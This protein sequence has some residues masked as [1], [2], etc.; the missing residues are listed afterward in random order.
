MYNPGFGY[1]WREHNG[2][3]RGV[4]E[5]GQQHFDS[6]RE[7]LDWIP[8]QDYLRPVYRDDGLMVGWRKWLGPRKQLD[9]V[10]WQIYVNGKKPE[11]LPGSTNDA[12]VVEVPRGAT[13]R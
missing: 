5:E 12:I 11:R 3:A 2:I 9:V 4:L 8:S 13:S 1:H 10:V 7:A 6:V